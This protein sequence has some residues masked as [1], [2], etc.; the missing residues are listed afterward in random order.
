MELSP[1]AGIQHLKRAIL[2]KRF[3][4]P[5]RRSF[6]YTAI[7]ASIAG[8][9]GYVVYEPKQWVTVG[10]L[11]DF[12]VDDLVAFDQG[13]RHIFIRRQSGGDIEAFSQRCSHQ[14][15]HVVWNPGANEF[16]CPCH[17]GMFD[18]SGTPIFGPPVRPLERYQ[19][20]V[21]S[22]TLQVFMS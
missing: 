11:N 22:G 3:A 1:S 8:I 10:A 15:C 9:V 6:A 19:T 14:G 4:N 13:R 17:R 21:E 2:Q 16:Q 5:T 18:P 12:P 20:R 7:G